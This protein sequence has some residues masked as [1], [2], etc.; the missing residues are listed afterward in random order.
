MRSSSSPFIVIPARNVKDCARPFGSLS[1][2]ASGK[3]RFE[4]Y[5]RLASSRK[6]GDFS[7]LLDKKRRFNLV[8]FRA[9]LFSSLSFDVASGFPGS[10][11]V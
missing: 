11:N 5:F 1:G 10:E 8:G 7:V 2:P 6:R 9:G 3:G 4:P